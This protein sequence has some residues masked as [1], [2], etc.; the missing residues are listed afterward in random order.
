VNREQSPIQAIFDAVDE[1]DDTTKQSIDRSPKFLYKGQ[2]IILDYVSKSD[3]LFLDKVFE[4]IEKNENKENEKIDFDQLKRDAEQE[5]LEVQKY[6]AKLQSKQ[7]ITIKE[8]TELYGAS[9]TSQQDYRGRKSNKNPLPYRQEKEGG[10]ILYDKDEIR[11]W[12]ENGYK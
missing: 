10:R 4:E 6:M 7:L 11:K 8:F 3:K 1:L 5:V 2:R 9:K 12:R